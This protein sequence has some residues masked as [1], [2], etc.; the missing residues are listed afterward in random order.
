[1]TERTLDARRRDVAG[2]IEATGH[3]DHGVELEQCQRGRRVV[4]VDL[5]P[6]E[7]LAKAS[8]QRVDVDLQTDGERGSGA[9]AATDAAVLGAGDRLVQME[10]A[11]PEILVTEC[12]VSEDLPSLVDELASIVDD[13]MVEVVVPLVA[14]GVERLPQDE[15]SQGERDAEAHHAAAPTRLAAG[16]PW[17][18]RA[19]SSCTSVRRTRAKAAIAIH[20]ALA[21]R[22]YRVRH[23]ALDEHASTLPAPTRPPEQELGVRQVA[24]ALET[25]IDTLPVHYRV[26]FVLRDLEGLSIVETAAC[27]AVPEA[28][29]K[30]RL[31]RA[32]ALLRSQ[33]DAALDVSADGVYAFGGQRCDRVVAAVMARI[34][35]GEV[36]RTMDS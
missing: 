12:V 27:L 30:T 14:R 19:A 25:A 13:D 4:Q 18:T 15:Q 20:E 6:L 9:E 24:S 11:A 21:R 2:G 33:L 10:L 26:A 22:R 1:M 8:R 32:R 28:T 3:P 23:I 36:P 35:A 5:T 29:V 34:R 31:H 17:L 7:L 16:E